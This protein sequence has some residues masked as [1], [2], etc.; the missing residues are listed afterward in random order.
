L[1]RPKNDYAA[2]NR[3]G[4]LDLQIFRAPGALG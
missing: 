2:T 3:G 1:D 4:S